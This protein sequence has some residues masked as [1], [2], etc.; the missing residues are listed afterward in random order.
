VLLQCV[1]VRCSVLQCVV[2]CGSKTHKDRPV[3]RAIRR[4]VRDALAEGVG[5]CCSV[6]QRVAV[7]G[8]V[9]QRVAVQRTEIDR[10]LRHSP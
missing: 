7:C 10:D 4:V 8:S 5:G 9:W 3:I 1:A 2:V 6:L